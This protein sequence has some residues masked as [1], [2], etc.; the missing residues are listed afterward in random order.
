MMLRMWLVALAMSVLISPSQA[1][2]RKEVPP[3]LPPAAMSKLFGGAFTLVD[4]EGRTRSD[5]DYLG[6]YLLINF[7][8]TQ[9]PDICPNDLSAMAEALEIVG[10]GKTILQPL[11]ITIDPK[12]DTPAALKSYVAAFHDDFV[13]LTG[14]EAQIRVA[15]SAYR[16]H[17]RKIVLKGEAP[18][19]YLASHSSMTYLMGPD[20]KFVTLFPYN[21]APDVMA[22]AIRRYLAGS[23]SRN[24]DGES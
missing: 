10:V 20:G 17:R 14:S 22:A 16:V 1:H 7:G 9:C 21:T 23:G 5:R 13:G 11:F 18:E 3:A 2:E 19:N 15:A 8:Y 12:R 24:M 6:R 4:H